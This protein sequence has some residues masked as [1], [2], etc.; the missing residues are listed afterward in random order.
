MDEDGAPQE[1]RHAVELTALLS[2]LAELWSSPTY[3]ASILAAIG[4]DVGVTEGRVL[5]HLG[6]Y[7]PLRP[8]MLA[9]RL[10]IGVPSISKAAAKL[11]RRGLVADRS[12]AGDQ[13]VRLLYLTPSGRVTVARM[14]Q[15]GDAA[16]RGILAGWEPAEAERFTVAMRTF[17]GAVSDYAARLR[18]R[19]G[20][21]PGDDRPTPRPRTADSDAT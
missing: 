13:R 15:V 4:A 18:S 3:Q 20:L 7:G 12:P 14:Y 11:R 1:L 19:A 10:E 21:A 16:V 17:V 6:Q 2:W 5:W 8:T 9:E